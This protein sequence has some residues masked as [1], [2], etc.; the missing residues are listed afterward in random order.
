[1][2]VE[3]PREKVISH[4]VPHSSGSAMIEA[5]IAPRSLSDALNRDD[6]RIEESKDVNL[7]S[8]Q[9]GEF[10]S[11]ELSWESRASVLA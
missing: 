6:D 8:E 2:L 11:I 1:M 7:S 3:T 10:S 5:Q 4:E 9:I